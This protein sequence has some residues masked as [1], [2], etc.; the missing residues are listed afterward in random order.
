MSSHWLKESY[1]EINRQIRVEEQDAL[2][3][4]KV[5]S[6]CCDQLFEVEELNE[7]GKCQE[8]LEWEE[9]HKND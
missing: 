2:M 9:K 1:A 8:C 5:R 3:P 4:I 7:D 6:K